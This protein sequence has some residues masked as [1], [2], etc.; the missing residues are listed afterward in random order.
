VECLLK[1]DWALVER[2]TEEVII[3]EKNKIVT[4]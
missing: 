3:P 2:S 1:V 4:R